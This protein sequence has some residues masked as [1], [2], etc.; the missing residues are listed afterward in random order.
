LD[1]RR[2]FRSDEE[3]EAGMFEIVRVE[4]GILWSAA[5]F[6]QYFFAGDAVPD[7]TA[8]EGKMK[9][10][11]RVWILFSV[12]FGLEGVLAGQGSVE[13]G[14]GIHAPP[15]ARRPPAA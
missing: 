8:R 5:N 7:S 13:Y 4:A 6:G 11:R 10:S 1:S 2:E 14:M 9:L 15:R 3:R 12:L